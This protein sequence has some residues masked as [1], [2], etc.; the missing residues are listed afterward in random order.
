[1]KSSRGKLI[2]VAISLFAL[3]AS[4]YAQSPREQLQQLTIQLQQSPNDNALRERIIKLALTVK[5]P[6]ALPPEAER[7]MVRGG[8]AFNGATSIADYQ[9][10]ATEFEQ[11]T[12]AAPWSG[13]AYYNLG[14]AQDKAE[15][16]D[17][18]LRSLKLAAL[19]SPGSK[20]AEKLSYAVEF[21]KEKAAA[22]R[23]AADT[24]QEREAA[25]LRKVQGARFVTHENAPFGSSSEIFEIRDRTLVITYRLHSWVGPI[26]KYGHS[27]PGEYVIAR[28]SYRDGAFTRTDS[29]FTYVYRIR[30]DGQALIAEGAFVTRDPGRRGSG[31][32]IPRE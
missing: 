22:A 5:P 7:R 11:A 28:V 25:L 6:P 19:A 32:T 10:A 18:A 21:R 2:V 23:A 27:R 9:A 14:V 15:D 24:P 8:A 31:A 26:V 13:D 16:Y 3:A 4:A 30:P 12:L 20:D 1:M 29:D 17:A